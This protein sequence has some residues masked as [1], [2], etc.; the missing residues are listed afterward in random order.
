MAVIKEGQFI[1]PSVNLVTTANEL[2][3][4]NLEPGIYTTTESKTIDSVTCNLWTVICLSSP[5]ASTSTCYTQIWIPA[6]GSI[7]GANKTMFIRTLASGGSGYSAFTT[8]INKDYLTANALTNKSPNPAEVYIQTTQPAVA[9]NKT[10][11]WINT[12]S[13]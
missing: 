12:S 4:V 6:S 2:D 7:T 3:Q 5:D 10:I 9:S 11:I 8:L 13:S 1:A